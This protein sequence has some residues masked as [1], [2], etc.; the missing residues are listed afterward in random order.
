MNLV[1][2][3]DSLKSDIRVYSKAYNNLLKIKNHK[4]AE[5]YKSKIDTC[6]YLLECIDNGH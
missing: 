4:G 3:I 5:Y 1:L 6:K 2:M